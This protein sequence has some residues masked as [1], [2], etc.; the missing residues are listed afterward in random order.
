M[1]KIERGNVWDHYERGAVV[2]ATTNIGWDE[3]G[4][5][6]M[7]AGVVLQAWRRF[8]DLAAWYGRFCREHGA[9]TPVCVHPDRLALFP[10]KPL[11]RED[12]AYSWNQTA[13]LRLIE[14]ST[15]QLAKLEKIGGFGDREIVMAFPGCGN[16]GL[17]VTAVHPILEKHLKSERFRI[18]DQVWPEE[19][20][21]E[22]R[23]RAVARR[24]EE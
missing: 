4:V 16:G 10:V 22:R 23:K 15:I 19:A 6:N 3:R 18:V 12:P 9:N 2:V 17:E 11:K 14:R 8:P 1:L 5:N 24:V 7:G 13:D 20:P 21:A